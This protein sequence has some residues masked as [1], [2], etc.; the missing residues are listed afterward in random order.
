[1]KRLKRKIRA[2]FDHQ[3]ERQKLP[4]DINAVYPSVPI[5]SDTFRIVHDKRKTFVQSFVFNTAVVLCLV[6]LLI[7]NANISESLQKQ[8][9][10]NYELRE[11]EKRVTDAL[12]RF[13]ASIKQAHFNSSKNRK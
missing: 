4:M 12:E 2:Y 3:V 11:V 6:V 8:A 10:F 7:V 5:S 1:M 13:H 9:P